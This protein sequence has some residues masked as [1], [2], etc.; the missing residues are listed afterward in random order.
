MLP[1]CLKFMEREIANVGTALPI[2][3]TERKITRA[4]RANG[5]IRITWGSGKKIVIKKEIEF[6]IWL[7]FII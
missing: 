4:S 7:N 2:L 3:V 6:E 1:T 5:N